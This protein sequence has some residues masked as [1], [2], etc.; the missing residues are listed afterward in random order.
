M[1]QFTA[2]EHAIAR[3]VVEGFTNREIAQALGRSKNMVKNFLR[4]MYDKS[5]MS[6]RLEFALWYLH[7]FSSIS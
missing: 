5:G 2:R 6:T 4:Q 7:H 1:I 3:M